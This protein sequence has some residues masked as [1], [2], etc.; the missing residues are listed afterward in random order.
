VWHIGLLDTMTSEMNTAN[1]DALRRGLR[2]RGYVE[3]QNLVFEYRS[4]DG[5]NERFRD[6]AIELV[7]KKID[8]IITRGTPAA[9]AAVA[10]SA[11]IPIVATAVAN[12]DGIGL[13]KSL[14]HPGGNLT[15]LSSVA[16]A[17]YGKRLELLR[18][19]LPRMTR[20]GVLTNLGNPS[21]VL[22]WKETQKIARSLGIQAQ[23]L[24][25]RK[26]EDLASAFQAASKE[27]A[28]AIVITGDTV[29]Q[30]NPAAITQLAIKHHLPTIAT[31]V[32]FVEVG[33]L[34]SYGVNYPQ[35]Y[36]QAAS[37]IDK[38]FRGA[39]PGDL[40]M[41]QPTSLELAINLKTASLL[42]I[43]I[44]PEIILRADR[45]IK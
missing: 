22:V 34:M 24:D 6:L 27:H 10:A 32:E 17:L 43:T 2:E 30:A 33:A 23:L 28:A 14:S 29:T 40:P 9:Q 16:A 12:P 45:I 19:T 26:P 15:G 41:E 44:P 38:I 3:G 25:V 8:L 13:V 31:G 21:S 42:G 35:L 1:L 5:H 39:K 36:Y 37:Y 4:A 20:V 18:E 7:N 11:T